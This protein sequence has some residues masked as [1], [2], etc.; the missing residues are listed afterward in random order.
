MQTRSDCSHVQTPA[1]VPADIAA[2][3]KE[4]ARQHLAQRA[5]R[6]AWW[7]RNPH[8]QTI[9]PAIIRQPRGVALRGT[10]VHTPDGDGVVVHRAEIDPA[11]PTVLILPGLESSARAAYVRGMAERVAAMRWNVAIMEFRGCSGFSNRAARLY[12]SGATDDVNA[13][14]E[15][16]LARG[17]REIMLVGFSLGANMT[18]KWLGECGG[19]CPARA[20]VMIAPPLD[21]AASA[22]MLDRSLAGLYSRQFVRSLKQ[23]AAAKDAQFSGRIDMRRVRAART[24]VEFDDAATAPLHGFRDAWDYYEQ[25]SC[26]QFLDRI[27]VPTLILAAKDDP[28]TPAES[29]PQRTIDESPWLCG[30]LSEH[31]GHQGF[32]S[33][34]WPWS[35]EYWA[36]SR[37]AEFLKIAHDETRGAL[38]R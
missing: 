23:K 3:V 19:R 26:G 37:T 6:P 24:I 9:W 13:V 30:V 20:A 29:W 35:A 11:A 25:S 2:R 31:G 32:V 1:G 22:Q 36:E 33:G 10:L 4:A 16:L 14:V 15:W 12:H 38:T 18:G 27:R 21:L 8:A 17:G 28:Y 34:L 7:L 5:F